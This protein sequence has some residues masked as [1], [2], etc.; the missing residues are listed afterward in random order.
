MSK[1]RKIIS[2]ILCLALC[3][4]L[5]AIILLC[6]VNANLLSVESVKKKLAKNNYYETVYNI[7]YES[8]NNYIMQSGFDSSVME[9]VFSKDDVERDVNRT[10]D[11]MYT[12]NEYKIQ[13]NA[14]KIKI[15]E[16]IQNY[17]SQNNYIISEENQ[18]SIDD[19][20]IIIEETYK[21]NIEYSSE[22]IKS[23]SKYIV[24]V[25]RGVNAVIALMCI[26]TIILT[27]IVYR[28]NRP[29][30]GISLVS[31]G[32]ICIFL[33]CYSGVNV[34]VNNILILNKAF[35]SVL[36]STINNMLHSLFILGIVLCV[37]GVI[38][39]I[40]SESKQKVR[41]IKLIE[42]HSQIIR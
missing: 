22:T 9:G 34:A 16:N 39:I 38:Y 40:L 7:I 20:E 3:I 19:F 5:S 30:V 12:G 23:L 28:I 37:A 31:T 24:I 35:S 36:I 2:Y 13:T 42:E 4:C 6:I 10:I 33:K 21:R 25:R 15:D 27:Y 41:K 8:C 17:V 14:L 18:K 32:A 1:K 26:F 11:Y 29:A